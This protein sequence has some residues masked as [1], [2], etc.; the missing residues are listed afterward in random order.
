[1]GDAAQDAKKEARDAEKKKRRAKK[2]ASKKK[3]KKLRKK[4]RKKCNK[5]CKAEKKRL[6]AEKKEKKE[7]NINGTK[8]GTDAL[9]RWK[10]QPE[11]NIDRAIASAKREAPH[12]ADDEKPDSKKVKAEELKAQIKV[13]Q[14]K[15]HQRN[16]EK[17][18]KRLMR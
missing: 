16:A 6:K 1:M 12:T 5:D 3:R 10:S 11:M 14:A 13:E 18:Q 2:M 17:P 15:R 4:K 9:D 7:A 8:A